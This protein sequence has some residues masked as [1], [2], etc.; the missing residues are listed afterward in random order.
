MEGNVFYALYKSR[1]LIISC[2]ADDFCL[3]IFCLFYI[4][5]L[6]KVA[7][8]RYPILNLI[9]SLFCRATLRKHYI[10]EA[11]LSVI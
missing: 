7:W 10:A 4:F 6:K 1:M 9:F 11:I 3:F 8:Y 2:K 5:I